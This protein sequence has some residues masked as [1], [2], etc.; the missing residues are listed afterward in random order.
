MS[1]ITGGD[2]R[3]RVVTTKMSMSHALTTGE[4]G[5]FLKAGTY[6]PALCLF[7]AFMARPY[8]KALHGGPEFLV[9]Q[10]LDYRHGSIGLELTTSGV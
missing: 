5:I 6:V 9:R 10:R 7:I 2:H 1:G 8:T 3:Q 4:A